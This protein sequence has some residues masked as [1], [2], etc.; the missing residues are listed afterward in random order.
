M[1]NHHLITAWGYN[2][3]IKAVL[4]TDTGYTK[5]NLPMFENKIKLYKNNDQPVL[6]EV[7]NMDRKLLITTDYNFYM[8]IV[9][10]VT[11]TLLLRRLSVPVDSTLGRLQFNFISSD[12]ENIKPGKYDFSISV[13]NQ[14]GIESF[15]YLNHTGDTVGECSIDDA[16]MPDF[17]NSLV[18]TTFNNDLRN[19]FTYK[20]SGRYPA[21][22]QQQFSNGVNTCAVYC[23]N[24]IGRFFI[25]G[26]VSAAPGNGDWIVLAFDNGITYHDFGSSIGP[27]TFTG[28]KSFNVTDS[29][30]WVRFVY[31][32]DSINTGT[33]DKILFRGINNPQIAFIQQ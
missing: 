25:E 30:Q 20:V 28:V 4:P 5:R 1:E 24:F 15:L 8:N 27:I 22:G 2:Q 31:L 10:N 16:P 14:S 12:I 29:L 19:T 3:L 21:T 32:P 18:I 33:V 17:K 13:V 26:S 11:G 23:T 7:R 6:M 9:D